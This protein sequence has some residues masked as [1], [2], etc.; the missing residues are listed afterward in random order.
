MKEEKKYTCKKC[1]RRAVVAVSYFEYCVS[2]M[3]RCSWCGELQDL[4]KTL[5]STEH[6][7]RMNALEKKELLGQVFI[8]RKTKAVVLV[9]KVEAFKVRL[10]HYPSKRVTEKKR[11]YFN[12]DYEP[13]LPRTEFPV[14][15]EDLKR[16]KK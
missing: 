14:K 3:G 10:F 6:C 1:L 8:N 15:P 12:Y 4:T 13:C 11:H 2:N 9:E 7:A 5:T 16:K